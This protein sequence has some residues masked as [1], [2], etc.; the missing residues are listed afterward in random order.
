MTLIVV[1]ICHMPRASSPGLYSGAF[2]TTPGL[3]AGQDAI[4]NALVANPAGPE[5][6]GRE[7]DTAGRAFAIT[8]P[9]GVVGPIL[10]IVACDGFFARMCRRN[11]PG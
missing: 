8:Y 7:M 6:T 4:R 9:F 10:V 3:A 2:T 11:W 5:R 1:W